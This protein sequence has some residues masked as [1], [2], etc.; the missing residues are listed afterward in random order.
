MQFDFV[1]DSESEKFVEMSRKIL[2]DAEKY[3]FH[4]D[5]LKM[6]FILILVNA[7]HD[8][9]KTVNHY[10]ACNSYGWAI[11]LDMPD[12]VEVKYIFVY[13]EHRRKG[14]FTCLLTL[15]KQEKKEIIV[16]TRE[17]VMLKALVA[18]GFELKGRTLDDTELKYIL[19]INI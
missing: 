8:V 3:S 5:S 17:S 18:R 9:N 15:L 13:P 19:N 4:H 12:F 7:I 6:F 11:M 14:F 16:C 2:A 1:G 10:I